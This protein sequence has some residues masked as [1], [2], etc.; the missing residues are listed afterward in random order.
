[1]IQFDL[2]SDIHL[3]FWLKHKGPTAADNR[4]EIKL[5]AES[6]LPRQ[7]SQVLVIARDLG[8]RNKQNYELLC[9]LKATILI[10]C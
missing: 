5:F 4:R 7:I 3:D 6:L 10:F 2:I 9:A 1:M 8:H